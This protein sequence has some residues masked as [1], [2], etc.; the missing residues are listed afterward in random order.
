MSAPAQHTPGPWHA[1]HWACHAPTTVGAI[2]PDTG[3]FAPIAECTG[4]GR[5]SDECLADARLIAAAPELLDA[6]QLLMSCSF[7]DQ[8]NHE[9]WF[10]CTAAIAKATAISEDTARR[11]DAAM[12]TDKQRD[13]YAQRQNMQAHGLQTLKVDCIWRVE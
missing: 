11:I 13:G 3:E 2:N 10:H 4:H 12:L 9:A 5:P 7:V 6:L 1:Q 8:R